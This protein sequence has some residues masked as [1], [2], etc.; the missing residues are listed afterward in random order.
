MPKF[1][2]V[3]DV[4]GFYNELI[5]ALKKSGFDE[6]NENHWL[7]VCGDV[8]DRGTQ[9]I[10]VMRYLKNLPRKVLIKGNHEQLFN[11]AVERCYPE[12][13]DYSNGTFDT[14]LQLG[15]A[16]KYT[17]FDECCIKAESRV[18]LFFNSM[19][20]YFETQNYVFCHSWIPVEWEDHLPAWY[21][22][23]RKYS[24]KEDWRY[25]HQSEWDGA[26]WVNPLDMAMNEM[27]IDKCIV[28]GHWH[29]SYGWG[30]QNKTF[31]DFGENAIFE[32]YNYKDKLIMIDACTAHTHKVNVLVIEDE[33]L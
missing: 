25:A 31:D 21:R 20:N 19:V 5:L 8:F 15:C 3:S 29:C 22:K 6:N 14:I 18:K 26:M 30:I 17:S 33:F 28:S 2:C 16:D 1:F 27:T 24:K 9:P 23:N 13:Y 11:E 4:H 32:P 7:I 12:S 10:Q